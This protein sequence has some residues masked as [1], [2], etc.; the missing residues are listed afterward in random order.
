MVG[1]SNLQVALFS[2]CMLECSR[3]LVMVASRRSCDIKASGRNGSS[4]LAVFRKV[5][6]EKIGGSII[7][8]TGTV[9]YTR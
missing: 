4:D 6:S 1:A 5:I 3:S 2:P 8:S 9:D 7:V